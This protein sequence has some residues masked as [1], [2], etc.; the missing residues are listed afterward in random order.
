MTEPRPIR[1]PVYLSC[2]TVRDRSGSVLAIRE[3]CLVRQSR[4]DRVIAVILAPP[5]SRVRRRR[6]RHGFDQLVVPSGR[7]L[8]SRLFGPRISIPA[9][10]VISDARSRANG[11]ALMD[12][13]AGVAPEV[14]SSPPSPSLELVG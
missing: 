1:I 12:G 3:R 7:S 2:R 9:K 8:L 11:L 14:V 13:R 6:D 10:Y 5:G 4:E